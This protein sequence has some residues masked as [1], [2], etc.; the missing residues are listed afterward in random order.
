MIIGRKL[1]QEQFLEKLAWKGLLTAKL[2][3]EMGTTTNWLASV[4]FVERDW[5][6]RKTEK[7]LGRE[8][9]FSSAFRAFLPVPP[10]P[11]LLRQSVYKNTE[12]HL[13]RGAGF[14]D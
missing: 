11:L 6:R 3:C 13:L 4:A 7:R 2:I 9:T 12:D 10:P 5:E 1:R 14:A 8:G